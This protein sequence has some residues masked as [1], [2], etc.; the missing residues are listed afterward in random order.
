MA[1]ADQ[2]VGPAVVIEIYKTSAPA[3]ILGVSAQSSGKCRVL[4]I[5]AAQIVV[6]RRRVAGKIRFHNV[7]ISIEVVVRS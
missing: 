2:N 7:K 5:R 3:E 4:E 1:V 6:E